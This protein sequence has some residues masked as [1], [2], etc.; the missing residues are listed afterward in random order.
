MNKAIA[1]GVAEGHKQKVGMVVVTGCI[2]PADSAFLLSIRSLQRRDATRTRSQQ[3]VVW[4]IVYL[5]LP[6]FTAVRTLCDLSRM[7]F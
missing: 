6:V 7:R 4:S 2:Y 1:T 5:I 3:R